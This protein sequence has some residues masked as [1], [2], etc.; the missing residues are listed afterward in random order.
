MASDALVL[1]ADN[2]KTGFSVGV[3]PVETEILANNVILVTKGYLR[4]VSH[5]ANPAFA[6]AQ[7]DRVAASTETPAEET[8][9]QINESEKSVEETT[10]DTVAQE[11]VVETPAVEASRPTVAAPLAF[12]APRINVTKMNY[13]SNVLK[14]S[15][16]DDEDAKAWVKAADNEQSDR[17]STR[18]NSSHIPLSRMPSSA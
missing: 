2:L 5:V 12:T 15:V 7:I 17:K 14:A 13:L 6:S 16:L 8:T 4:E 10:K 1:A 18:L 3:E 9:E 11:A